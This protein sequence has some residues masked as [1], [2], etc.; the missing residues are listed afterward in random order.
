MFPGGTHPGSTVSKG[1]TAV[2]DQ[3]R[4]SD[5]PPV[6]VN[7]FYGQLLN[8]DDFRAD[9]DYHRRMRYLHNRLLHG[10]GIVDGCYVE[11]D[12]HGVLVGPGV[13]IDSL[14]RELVL[15]DPVRI[16]LPP[17][18]LAEEQTLWYVVAMWEEIPSAPVAVGDKVVFSR[19]IERCAVS[20]RPIPPADDDR[21]LL[22]AMLTAAAGSVVSIDTSRRRPQRVAQAIDQSAA[23][24]TIHDD[25]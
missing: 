13:A 10:W 15:P 17:E 21:A 24:P 5:G 1:T 11:D 3:L 12:G 2:S 8:A 18:A 9:Q 6:R 16:E 25:H 19:W 7:F 22:L 20:I 4:P 14:G 23:S